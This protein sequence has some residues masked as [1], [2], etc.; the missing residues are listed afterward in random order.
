MFLVLGIPS[1]W[2]HAQLDYLVPSQPDRDNPLPRNNDPWKEPET[3]E[4]TPDGNPE[5]PYSDLSIEQL[6]EIL[7][8][9]KESAEA[10]K[11]A[12]EEAKRNR[13]YT[14]YDNADYQPALVLIQGGNGSGTGFICTIENIPFLV[15]NVHVLASAD[16]AN[17]MGNGLRDL[18]AKTIDGSELTLQ[19]IFGATDHDLAIIRFAEQD[20]YADIA[21]SFDPNVGQNVQS[22]DSIVIPGNSK[23]GG[24]MIWT[25]GEVVGVGPTKIEH[26]APIYVGNSG[27]PIIHIES[28]K[29]IGVLSYIQRV[30]IDSYFDEES[31]KRERSAIKDTVRYFGYRIDSAKD[32]YQIDLRKFC[33]QFSEFEAFQEQRMHIAQFLYTNNNDWTEDRDLSIIINDAINQ[34]ERGSVQGK[35][36]R[37]VI[38]RVSITVSRRLNGLIQDETYQKYSQ[39]LHDENGGTIRRHDIYPFFKE[40]IERELKIRDYLSN[41]VDDWEGRLRGY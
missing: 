38:A 19:S 8:L 41:N 17:S 12:Q 7:R 13:T 11:K 3:E 29:V 23:G 22:G 21:L 1:T 24:T 28:G 6:E 34:I 10:Q 30:D 33:R 40:E 5:A 35:A 36:G 20:A 39:Y 16:A 4:P 31:F 27:S 26:N 25:E 18:K 32:W 14:G 9:K 37:D 15:T 2:L